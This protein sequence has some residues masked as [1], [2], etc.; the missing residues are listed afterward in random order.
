M[1]DRACLPVTHLARG[2]NPRQKHRTRT[3]G[4]AVEGT[5]LEN[6]QAGN[7]LV[8]SNPTLSATFSCRI[9]PRA[10]LGPFFFLFQ[11]AL[12]G[13]SALRRLGACRRMGLRMARVSL[14]APLDGSGTAR[15]ILAF[16]MDCCVHGFAPVRE[17]IWQRRPT[18]RRRAVRRTGQW[19]PI[20]KSGGHVRRKPGPCRKSLMTNRLRA[21]SLAQCRTGLGRMKRTT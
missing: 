11:K 3:G 15:N 17:I 4:R 13:L 19:R 18:R 20:P 8:G 12:A 21:H 1:S 14:R 2:T 10:R 6:Q 16:P 7:R 9:R 5:G